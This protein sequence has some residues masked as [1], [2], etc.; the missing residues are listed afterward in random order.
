MRPSKPKPIRLTIRTETIRQIDA[1]E[2]REIAG[3]RPTALL[4]ACQC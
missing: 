1:G 2:L 3:G 4:T